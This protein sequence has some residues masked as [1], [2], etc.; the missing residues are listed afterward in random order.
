MA[1]FIF[2]ETPIV[3]EMN[4]IHFTKQL[5]HANH[6]AFVLLNLER[7][8]QQHFVSR[9]MHAIF[10]IS[11]VVSPGKPHPFAA[12]PSGKMQSGSYLL[13]HL[14]LEFPF[15]IETGTLPE[16]NETDSKLNDKSVI[17]V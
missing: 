11:R 7:S 16:G 2:D 17:R 6:A 3:C 10:N 14:T 15:P 9:S 12:L 8:R 13:A 4:L 1:R 5:V